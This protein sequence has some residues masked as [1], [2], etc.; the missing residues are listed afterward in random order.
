MFKLDSFGKFCT[1]RKHSS[2]I[3]VRETANFL[4]FGNTSSIGVKPY[5]FITFQSL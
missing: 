4:T 5:F 3:M 1:K 2:G